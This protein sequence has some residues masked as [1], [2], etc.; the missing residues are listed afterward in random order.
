MEKPLSLSALSPVEDHTAKENIKRVREYFEENLAVTVLKSVR[1]S[2]TLCM[3]RSD[4]GR[5]FKLCFVFREK[6]I[7]ALNTKVEV[8]VAVKGKT[9]DYC[10]F[11]DALLDESLEDLQIV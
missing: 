4:I 7:N 3:I 11:L 8:K 5:I 6:C 10:S 2:L 9:I 1:Y